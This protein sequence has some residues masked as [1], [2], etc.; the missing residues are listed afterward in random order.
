MLSLALGYSSGKFEFTL[1]RELLA[2]F[3]ELCQATGLRSFVPP[4]GIP[5]QLIFSAACVV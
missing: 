1:E 2:S 3:P 5:C 4:G